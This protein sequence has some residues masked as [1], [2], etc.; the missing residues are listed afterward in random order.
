MEEVFIFGHR[1]PDTD[2]VMS[3]IA[4]SYLKKQLGMKAE[5]R[6]IGEINDESKYIL[7]KFLTLGIYVYTN[8]NAYAQRFEFNT[9]LSLIEIVVKKIF[10]HL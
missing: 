4:L 5:A 7:N 6:V 9:I 3:S 10:V 1:N 8:K 2:S